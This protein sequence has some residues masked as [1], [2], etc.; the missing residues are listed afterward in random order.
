MSKRQSTIYNQKNRLNHQGWNIEDTTNAVR[1]NG[2]SETLHHVTS[3]CVAAK[4]AIDAG[5]RVASEVELDDG[6]GECDILAYGLEDRHPIV[7]ELERDFDIEVQEKKLE[8]YNVGDVAEVWVIDL[9]EAPSHP[10]SLY[11]HI[12]EQTGLES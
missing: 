4:V 1:F 9:D 2:G 5:Y 7:I 8:Q 6:S 11:E 10:D 3:K 12:A